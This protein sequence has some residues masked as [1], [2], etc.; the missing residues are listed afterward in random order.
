MSSSVLG[1]SQEH[2][3]LRLQWNEIHS[4]GKTK[5]R[6]VFNIFFYAYSGRREINSL[7]QFWDGVYNYAA[8]KYIEV[9]QFVKVLTCAGLEEVSQVLLVGAVVCDGP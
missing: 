5:C 3:L 9:G 2:L 7:V 8:I 4:L 1:R 6:V